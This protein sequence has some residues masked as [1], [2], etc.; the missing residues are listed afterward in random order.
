MSSALALGSPPLAST[1]RCDFGGVNT[2]DRKRGAA[3]RV[4]ELLHENCAR[5]QCAD[6][7]FQSA[8]VYLRRRGLSHQYPPLIAAERD[9]AELPEMCLPGDRSKSRQSRG[10]SARRPANGEERRLSAA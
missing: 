6:R 9:Y 7:T 10:G 3:L 8:E 1:F 2:A 4:P 5:R